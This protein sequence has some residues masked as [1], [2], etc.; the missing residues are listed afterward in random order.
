MAYNTQAM[1]RG[2]VPAPTTTTPSLTPGA[3]AVNPTSIGASR[4]AAVAQQRQAGGRYIA[5]AASA[6]SAAPPAYSRMAAL[7]QQRQ[8]AGPQTRGGASQA[9]GA[10]A[11][12]GRAVRMQ[13][14]TLPT[15]SSQDSRGGLDSNGSVLHGVPPMDILVRFERSW[16]IQDALDQHAA[17]AEQRDMLV[18][19]GK[20]RLQV[21]QTQ[22]SFAELEVEDALD[23]AKGM[24]AVDAGDG[25]RVLIVASRLRSAVRDLRLAARLLRMEQGIVDRHI[26]LSDAEIEKSKVE[27]TYMKEVIDD[28]SLVV[29]S[30]ESLPVKVPVDESGSPLKQ[31]FFYCTNCKVGGH[32]QRFCEYFLDRPSWRVYP[33]QKWFEDDKGNEFHC[34]LGRKLVDFADESHFSRIAMY[35]RGRAWLEEKTK[36][37]ALGDGLMPETYIIEQGKWKG[38]SPPDDSDVTN[39]PWFVKEAD[40]NWGTSVHVCRKPSECLGLAKSDATYVVQ[41]HIKDPLLTEDG[42][43]CHIKF[44][45]LMLGFDDGIRWHLYTYKEGYLSI[46]PN[47]WSPEDISKETQVTIIRSERIGAWKPWPEAYPKCKSAVGKVMQRAVTQGKLEGRL[48]KKQFEILSA[49]FIVDTNGDV[50][51]FEFNMSPVLKDPHDAPK[52]N[53]ADMIRGAL[54]IVVPW[55]GGGPGM[56]DFVGEYIGLPPQPKAPPQP[57]QEQNTEEAA[58]K[59]TK[60]NDVEAANNEQTTAKVGDQGEVHV[61]NRGV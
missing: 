29:A 37:L 16:S 36:V 30:D 3:R 49:D 26:A 4:V 35:L 57:T 9:S 39:L 5:N 52:V 33:Q 55:E 6:A 43:K 17:L 2:V 61:C 24:S 44:Y 58:N 50:W 38:N 18:E 20:K 7:T 47:A 31:K 59:N 12:A 45:I 22:L 51:L 15:V 14:G 11:T 48:H 10:M 13:D 46:S 19:I 53:D 21:R 25:R 41:Q 42:R 8:A 34:P 56:W 23:V 54:S 1:P 40:R 60:E 28:K 32:G 27:M